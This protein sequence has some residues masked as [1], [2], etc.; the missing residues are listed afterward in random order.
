MQTSQLRNAFIEYF[1]KNN[2]TQLRSS[3]VVPHDDPTILFTNAGMNQF[4]KIFL[5]SSQLEYDRVVTSQK[6]I[7][8]GGK[9]NDLD[10][11]TYN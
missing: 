9:H 8:V 1:K 5:G 2:H 3:S 7:R 11:V 4:K 10:N 6:C